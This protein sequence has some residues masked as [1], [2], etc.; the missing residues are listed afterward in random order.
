MGQGLFA[1]L[2]QDL[3]EGSHT[4]RRRENKRKWGVKIKPFYAVFAPFSLTLPDQ[5]YFSP[6]LLQTDR[7]QSAEESAHKKPE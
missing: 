7:L 6:L 4:P 2:G 5:L 1:G 3:A